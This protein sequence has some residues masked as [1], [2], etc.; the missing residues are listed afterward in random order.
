M[1]LQ[2]KALVAP[3]EDPDSVSNNHMVAHNHL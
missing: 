3:A 1:D 2:F